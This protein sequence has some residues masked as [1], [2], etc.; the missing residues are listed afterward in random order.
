MPFGV[1]LYFDDQTEKTIL[2]IWRTLADNNQSSGML[3]A[4]LRPHITLAI[5]EDLDCQ[6]CENELVKITAKTASLPLQLTHLGIFTNPE[7]VIFAAPL[8]TEELLAFHKDLQSRLANE[9]KNP[10]ELYKPDKWVPH[11]TLSLGYK[12]ENLANIIQICQTLPFPME[13]RAIQLGVVN[14]KPVKD[15]FNYDFLSFEG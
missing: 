3:G 12:I 10:N 8:V 14:F 15:L 5:Y 2:N 11:C 4:G 13:V 6:P 1:M 9:G 7:P